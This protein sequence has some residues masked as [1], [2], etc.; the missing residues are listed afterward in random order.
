MS[1]LAPRSQLP[2]VTVTLI[3]LSVGVSLVSLIGDAH[4]ALLSFLI[5]EPG[6]AP[7][8]DVLSGEVWR[9]VT[10]I[11]VHFGFLHLLFNMMWL[12][13]LG[14]AI[15]RIKGAAFLGLFVAATGIA[16]N[17]AQY[18]ITQS[19]LFGGMSGV[20]YALLG[21]VWIQ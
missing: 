5:A 18:F 6:H 10:P 20:V 15:E 11:F 13:D 3:A 9:L 21:Y 2:V 14:R 1:L 17:V 4:S 19:P 12:W 16:S 7:F 8:A